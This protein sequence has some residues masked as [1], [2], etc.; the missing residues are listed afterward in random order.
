MKQ[1]LKIKKIILWG[2]GKAKKINACWWFS[3]CFI[4]FLT[5]SKESFI[6]IGSGVEF[7]ISE[8]VN[9]VFKILDYKGKAIY[10]K[11]MP[12]GTPQ[13]I[14]DCTK[15]KKYG[16]HSKIKFEEGLKKTYKSFL[17]EMKY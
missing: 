15:A 2:N 3:G 13:K 10:D 7:R 14:L 17:N 8:Y 9:K 12:N 5:K 6:N 1:R 11:K 16:W 4:F